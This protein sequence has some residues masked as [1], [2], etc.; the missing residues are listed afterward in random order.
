[1]NQRMLPAAML[2]NACMVQIKLPYK[3]VH[4]LCIPGFGS[5]GFSP[6]LP[7][8][9][10]PPRARPPAAAAAAG[11]TAGAAAA[12]DGPPSLASP[13]SAAAVCVSAPAF[14]SKAPAF[15]AAASAPTVPWLSAPTGGGAAP[16]SPAASPPSCSSDAMVCVPAWLLHLLLL[17]PAHAG[18]KWGENAFWSWHF[19]HWAPGYSLKQ[20][21]EQTATQAATRLSGG[22][23]PC[24]ALLRGGCCCRLP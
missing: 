7:D 15:A 5:L 14:V 24:T 1:M 3:P 20:P 9:A 8:A 23:L 22:G 18:V 2:S 17:P 12:A 11:A 21:A 10:L 4:W 19:M 13:P 6:P 16:A